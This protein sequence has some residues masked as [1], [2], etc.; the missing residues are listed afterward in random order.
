MA[1]PH[2]IM[3]LQ[4]K[5]TQQVERLKKNGG[6][7]ES[8]INPEILNNQGATELVPIHDGSDGSDGNF[9]AVSI[10][11]EFAVT[12]TQAKERLQMLQRFV[13][14][15]LVPNEDYGII[16]GTKKPSLYKSGAEKL[17]D[18][19][20][21]AKYVEVL[22]RVED[23]Q[24]PFLHYEV[25]LILRSKRTGLVEAE[26]IGSANSKEKKFAKQDTFSIANSL[27]K[28]AKKRALVDAVLSSTRSSGIFS[29]D[30]EDIAN[31]PEQKPVQQAPFN[32]PATPQKVQPE[33]ATK[34]QL[35]QIYSLAKELALSAQQAKNI[36][37]LHFKVDD[38]EK[39]TKDQAGDL[40]DLLLKR[41]AN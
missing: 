1:S 4:E 39:L 20:G 23:W 19:F 7:G 34:E 27:L 29:Q 18:A 40:I 13:Q 31:L 28:M 5:L 15:F 25:K 14:E 17:T 38:S 10:V 33:A 6:N 9:Q 16:P 8:V 41:K 35:R 36:M 21:F 22:N 3:T 24:T 32:Q 37:L 2:F 26:G 11:P 12:L 30:M